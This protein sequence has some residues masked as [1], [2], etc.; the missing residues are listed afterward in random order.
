M[1]GMKLEC[2]LCLRNV[3][4]E[5]KDG[6]MKPDERLGL[7]DTAVS[8]MLRPMIGNPY[9]KA[10]VAVAAF[11]ALACVA[12]AATSV[13]VDAPLPAHADGEASAEAMMPAIGEKDRTLKLMLTFDAAMTNKVEML[14]GTGGEVSPRAGSTAMIIGWRRGEWFVTGDRLR[15]T[16]TTAATDPTADGPRT[17]TVNIR[18]GPASRVAIFEE[19]WNAG[20]PSRSPVVF[21]G[22]EAETLLSWLDP[23]G[24]DTLSVTS[25]GGAENAAAEAVFSVDGTNII[26]R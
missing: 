16:F 26:L 6:K 11:S 17:L 8:G 15:Q 2:V 14:L 5:G 22:L 7:A 3:S 18:L 4:F 12:T 13:R 21:N 10:F 19:R 1:K 25:R 9:I 23:S 24:W 20:V